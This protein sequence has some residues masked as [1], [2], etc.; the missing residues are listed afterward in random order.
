MAFTSNDIDR[1]TGATVLGAD[2]D[3]I[4]SIGQVYVDED[5]APTWATVRTGLFGTSESF[6][7]LDAADLNGSDVT[8]PFDKD[9]VKDAPR[10]ES[11]G[12]LSEDET[13]SL[14]D[15]YAGHGS[16]IGGSST[17]SDTAEYSDTAGYSD[18]T[19]ASADT[20]TADAGYDAGVSTDRR[21][22]ASTEGYDTSGPTTDDAMTRSEERLHVGTRKVE[23]GRARLRKHIVTEQ[24]TVTVPVTHEEATLV[25][26][27]IT[28]ANLG[29]ATSGS[30]ISEEEHEVVLHGEEVV[31]SKDTVPVERVRLGTEQH[32]EQQ[33]V[34]D[35]VRKEQI[36]FV[37]GDGTTVDPT[38]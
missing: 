15:Y 30:E 12:E 24:Q 28:E 8:V 19:R 5:G 4:G 22:A 11:D 29:D 3:K 26:E 34:T 32:T 18:T 7:P 27:P 38:R 21:D 25:R 16:S 9:V 37:D 17:S 31:T 2:H 14:Y 36:D 33:Q 20:G 23:T 1:L 35:E 6:I 10:V 13:D